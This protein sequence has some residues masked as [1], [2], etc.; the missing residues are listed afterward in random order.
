MLR[1]VLISTYELGHQPLGLASPAAWLRQHGFH[2]DCVDLSVHSLP[3]EII[4]QAHLIAFHIPMHTAT[5]LAV[6]YVSHVQNLNATAHLCFYGLYASLNETYLRQL[7][8]QTILGGEYEAGLLNLCRRLHNNQGREIPAQQTEPLISLAR[9]D[10]FIP[11]R[12][13]LPALSNYAHL[14]WDHHPPKKTGY[15]E[16]TRGCK[17]SCRHCPIVPVY[18]GKFRIIQKEVVL[19]DIRQQVMAG[20]E[21]ITFGDPDFFNGVGHTIPI[22]Q[23][24]HQEFPEVTYDVIIKIEHLLK[25]SHLLPILKKTGCVIITSAV[26]AVD[27]HVLSLLNKK[28]TVEDFI[29]VVQLCQKNELIL[30]PTF[31][32]FT[33]W[34]TLTDYQKFLSS[35]FE[36]ELVDQTAPIQLAIRLL[37]TEGSKLLEIRDIQELL[38][39]FNQKNLCYEWHHPDPEMDELHA[40]VLRLV[41]TGVKNNQTRQEI[42]ETLWNCVS[43]KTHAYASLPELPFVPDRTAIPYLN[44]PW[45]C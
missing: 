12:Q 8:A 2:V 25:Q 16:T 17:H 35:L 19:A 3:P 21:H 22:L 31:I 27:N 30:N 39:R 13:D 23:A 38:G 33:P 18:E 11:D 9:Q 26:E 37:V 15:V 6:E 28:H 34:T 4:R 20:A 24:L 29:Q 14:H 36:L 41:S 10:F 5:R 42:F 40:E 32:P 1:I 45:Y 44:E 7:G 43:T